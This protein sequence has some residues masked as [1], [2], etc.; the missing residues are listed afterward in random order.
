MG[1]FSRGRGGSSPE[2]PAPAPAPSP[3]PQPQLSL[4]RQRLAETSVHPL[5]RVSVSDLSEEAREI[6]EAILKK[7]PDW[8]GRVEE[9]PKPASDS[10][11]SEAR[12]MA[13]VADLKFGISNLK[14]ST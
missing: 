9:T 10:K 11:D 1:L 7:I 14:F 6:A 3:E 5:Q 2:S 12:E 4:L 13:F 8:S